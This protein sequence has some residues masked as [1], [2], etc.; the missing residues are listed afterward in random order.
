MT[1]QLESRTKKIEIKP[2]N[3]SDHSPIIWCDET[4]LKTHKFWRINED[5]LEKQENIKFLKKEI[6]QY[7]E[8]NE[9][10]GMHPTIVWDAFKAVIR[11]SLIKLNTME[12]KK[13]KEKLNQLTL[14]LEK[15]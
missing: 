12:R 15:N 6:K 9:T 1:K 2:R 11:G 7:F 5:L 3:I 8:L 10:L 14:E 13:K 4:P